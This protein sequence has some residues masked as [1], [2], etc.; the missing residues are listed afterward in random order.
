M[1]VNAFRGYLDEL[2]KLKRENKD[3][4]LTDSQN[5]NKRSKK[6]LR[7][8]R[9]NQNKKEEETFSKF[10]HE[11][12]VSKANIHTVCEVCSSLMWLME[13]IWVCKGCKLTCHKKCAANVTVSCR[14][15]S[16]IQ[17][18]KRVFGAPIENLVTEDTRIPMIADKLISAIEIKGKFS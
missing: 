4:Q 16:L 10:G 15:K 14:D 7:K 11:F 13:K 1:G 2:Q 12:V 6:K 5:Q 18:G 3:I 9:K 17:Q 8:S